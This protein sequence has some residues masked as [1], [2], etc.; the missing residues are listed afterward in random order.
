MREANED[1]E[2]E[3]SWSGS[4]DGI[5]REVA[6]C[7]FEDLVASTYPGLL[8][9]ARRL[10]PCDAEAWDLLH[11]TL[12]RA[13]RNVHRLKP[14]SNVRA[15]LSSIMF[16]LFVDR[17]RA[18]RRERPVDPAAFDDM[19]A[20]EPESRAM[21]GWTNLGLEEVQASLRRLGSPFREVLD[22]HINQKWSYL[23]IA[24]GLGIP[25]STVGTRLNR[26]RRKMR[27]LL[28][29]HAE[30]PVRHHRPAS[31]KALPTSEFTHQEMLRK[32]NRP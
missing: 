30:R 6:V 22:L 20:P 5:S 27:S 29:S 23:Q 24:E 26:A 16:H 2:G 21:P 9:E 12:E 28:L 11:D 10:Q 31:R 3:S 4:D 7:A 17:Y 15:W 14:Q 13:L 8:Q 32:E 25:Q 18:L 1:G 19:P